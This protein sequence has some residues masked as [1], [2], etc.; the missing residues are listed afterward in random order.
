MAEFNRDAVAERGTSAYGRRDDERESRHP[1]A[2]S[3]AEVDCAAAIGDPAEHLAHL[4]NTIETEIIPRLMLAHSADVRAHLAAASA[5]VS[6]ARPDVEEFTRLLLAPEDAR[7]ENYLR[8][9]IQGGFPLDELYLD[10]LA[11]AA[12]RLG[13]LWEED[14]CSFSEVTIG[15]SRLHRRLLELGPSF[16]NGRGTFQPG[17]RALLVAAPGEQHTF[18]LFMVTEFFRR[19]GWE[20]WGEPIQSVSDLADAVRENWFE[21]VGLSAGSLQRLEDIRLA[22]AA[23]RKAS[24]N[25]DVTVMVGG[26]LFNLNPQF[27]G[28]VGADAFGTDAQQALALAERLIRR[29]GGHAAS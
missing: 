25:H 2:G 22:V 17:K 27:A 7:A 10:L 5:G 13:V 21:L 20:V 9:L 18:G 16:H 11:P 26:P 12:R 23:V 6:V 24:R 19:E 4:V 14:L 28:Q 15:L 1:D 29:S 8:S 3:G